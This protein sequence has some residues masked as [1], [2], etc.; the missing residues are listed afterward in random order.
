MART[1][2]CRGSRRFWIQ[3]SLWGAEDRLE[4]SR[5]GGKRSLDAAASGEP[6]TREMGGDFEWTTIRFV[7]PRINGKK[8]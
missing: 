2:Q 6:V 5:S 4:K 7:Q 1:A 3:Q 8:D